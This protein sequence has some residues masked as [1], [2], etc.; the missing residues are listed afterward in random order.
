[1]RR[2]EF[3]KVSATAVIAPFLLPRNAY[4]QVPSIE[5]MGFPQIPDLGD[6]DNTGHFKTESR[7][8]N[9]FY[10]GMGTD[11]GEFADDID[12][13]DDS[14]VSF[15]HALAKYGWALRHTL[16]FT[17]GKP[18]GEK[19]S[20]RDTIGDPG[21][22]IDIALNDISKADEEGFNLIGF[23]LGGV[24]ATAVAM[25]F[26]EKT[27]SLTL[28][29]SPVRGIEYSFKKWFLIEGGKKIISTFT[30][31]PLGEEEVSIYLYKRWEDK[32]FKSKLDKFGRNFANSKKPFNIAYSLNDPILNSQS[33]L[34][35]GAR[36]FSS[37]YPEGDLFHAHVAH[38]APMRN[39]E[40]SQILSLEI[41]YNPYP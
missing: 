39:D 22:A 17:W 27:R 7:V 6:I 15:R 41:G 36:Y 4:S 19:F 5:G 40:L 1:M 23:S 32:N 16:F 24:I 34:T 31:K 9:L 18:P 28:I 33:V 35:D 38:S 13:L 20:S 11:Q 26:P 10:C 2:G 30:N 25:E 8:K 14:F 21:K 29:S 3:L 37:T 12:P